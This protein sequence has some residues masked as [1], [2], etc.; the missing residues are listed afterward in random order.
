MAKFLVIG[1]REL[2]GEI[3]VRGSKNAS[4]PALAASLLFNEEPLFQNLP[5]IED[6]FRMRELVEVLKKSGKINHEIAKR[7]RASIL[8]TGPALARFG[9]VKFPHPGGCVIGARPID[10]F[11]DGWRAMGVATDSISVANSGSSTV[12]SIPIYKLRASHGLHGCEYTFRVPSVTGTE[13]LILTALMANGDTVLKNA[14][15]EPEVKTLA[16]FLNKNGAKIRG[17]GTPTIAIEGRN[18]KL[19]E[20]RAAFFAPPDRIEAGSLAVLGALLA[21]D[22]CIKNFPAGELIS[23]L[24]T[25]KNAGVELDNYEIATNQRE[26]ILSHIILKRAKKFRAVDIKTK[27]YPGYPTDLQAPFAVLATQADGASRIHETIFE[28]RLN[29][30]EDLNMMGANITLSDSRMAIINGPSIL[31]GRKLESP[32]IRAGLAF[33]VAALTAEGQSE[34]GNIY[35][36]DRGYERIDERLQKIGADI[37]RI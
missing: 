11:L 18:G 35:Q 2:E 12:H 5:Q 8:L 13:G 34:I 3:E 29:Y 25:L 30:I 19:L 37:K 10:V 21:K 31:R 4:L 6:V 32:D 1:G 22:L 23:L 24:L 26:T 36:I 9:E 7:I 17:A 33:I 20:S 28:G 14:A 15:L 27:E 16:E